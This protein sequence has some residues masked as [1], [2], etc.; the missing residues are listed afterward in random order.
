MGP[1]VLPSLLSSGVVPPEL[2]AEQVDVRGSRLVEKLRTA[3]GTAV[4]VGWG[5]EG[6]PHFV[7]KGL[8]RGHEAGLQTLYE[9]EEC[10][11]VRLVFGALSTTP[12]RVVHCIEENLSRNAPA[13]L[14]LLRDPPIESYAR[15]RSA[16][17]AHD[18]LPLVRY[19]REYA[20]PA[21]FEAL[22]RFATFGPAH[23]V[24]PPDRMVP[25]PTVAVDVLVAAAH[26]QMPVLA[27]MAE[28]WTIEGISQPTVSDRYDALGRTAAAR[29]LIH[30]RSLKCRHPLQAVADSEAALQRIKEAGQAALHAVSAPRLQVRAPEYPISVNAQ[31]ALLEDKGLLRHSAPVAQQHL[32]RLDKVGA[33]T[34]AKVAAAVR[35]SLQ[36][37][38]LGR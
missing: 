5:K 14:A 35:L 37:K 9:A 22:F 25:P 21:V 27:A 2:L 7:L 20:H 23:S 19:M 26:Y 18:E 34:D 24:A 13:L 15:P 36:R 17:E 10:S 33:L 32:L 16:S 3:A 29:V 38:P 6:V 4:A 1:P 31:C 30:L 8:E 28:K 11:N 12:Q